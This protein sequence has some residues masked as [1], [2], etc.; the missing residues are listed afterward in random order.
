MFLSDF[1]G[2]FT[3]LINKH[4]RLI[5]PL[6]YR[7]SAGLMYRCQGLP[8][9]P[10]PENRCDGTVRNGEGDLMLCQKCDSIR[11]QQFLANKQ[12]QAASLGSSSSAAVPASSAS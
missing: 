3:F 6:L 4:F 2:L 10:C 12:K 1:K 9:G 11:A 7:I 8:D 5:D